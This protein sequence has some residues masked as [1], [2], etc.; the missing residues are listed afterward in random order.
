VAI[1]LT[2]RCRWTRWLLIRSR[3]CVCAIISSSVE[4][5]F[6][7]SATAIMRIVRLRTMSSM[8][9][10]GWR[11]KDSVSKVARRSKMVALIVRTTCAFMA[12]E[13]GMAKTG[14]CYVRRTEGI[15]SYVNCEAGGFFRK[16]FI[17]NR[18]TTLKLFL[19]AG[20]LQK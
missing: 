4:S 1:G 18:R 7:R 3:N 14:I 12:T 11:D 17:P 20:P 6:R 15:K 8:H 2:S 9:C 5:V 16:A 10:G 13:A 19:H